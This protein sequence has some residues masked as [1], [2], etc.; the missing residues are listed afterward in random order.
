MYKL[1]KSLK[2]V[3]YYKASKILKR[4]LSGFCNVRNEMKAKGRPSKTIGKMII[5]IHMYAYICALLAVNEETTNKL[6]LSSKR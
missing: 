2:F 6:S 5:S 3:Q 4:I 1:Y